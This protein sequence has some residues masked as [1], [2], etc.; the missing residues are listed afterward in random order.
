MAEKDQTLV[1][2]ALAGDGP[3]FGDLVERY[4]RLVRGIIWETVRRPD[5]VE[6]LVQEAFC[7]AYE[8]LPSLRQQAKFASWLWSIAANAALSHQYRKKREEQAAPARAEQQ[9]ALSLY[10]RRP[11]EVAE[12]HEAARL[13]WEALDRLEPESRRLVVL[14]YFEECG[15]QEIARFLDLSVAAVR[16]R[17]FKTRDWLRGE[18]LGKLGAEIQVP[19][20]A[21]GRMREKVMAALPAGFFLAPQP[22]RWLERWAQWKYWA[23]GTAAGLG[24]G[25]LAYQAFQQ[26]ANGLSRE[27]QR[28]E[29]QAQVHGEPSVEWDPPQPRAGQQVRIR[30]ADLEVKAGDQAELH[31]LTDPVYPIDQVV[32]LR[33]EGGIWGTDLVVPEKAV[34][35]SF[36]VTPRREGPQ[37]LRST[38]NLTTR[39]RLQRYQ[40]A[41]LVYDEAGVP[42]RGAAYNQ[43]LLAQIQGRPSE[44]ML[45]W[46]EDELE[47]HPDHF[48]V[49]RL[50]WNALEKTARPALLAQ[51]RA[52][53]ERLKVRY[54]DH[55][56]LLWILAWD[57][58]D[59]QQGLQ[60]LYQRFPEHERAEE[61]AYL[62][63]INAHRDT[64]SR[65]LLVLEEFLTLFPQGRY[66]GEMYRYYLSTLAQ[67]APDRAAQRADSLIGH[68]LVLPL[69]AQQTSMPTVGGRLLEGYA[70][71]LRFDLLLKEGKQAEV[72]PL[73]ERLIASGLADPLPY[74]YIGKK[75]ADQPVPFL[76]GELLSGPRDLP[77]ATQVLEAGLP[78]AAPEQQPQPPWSSD[79]AL[80][81]ESAREEQRQA[82]LDQ[83]L[84][85]CQAYVQ[86]LAQVYLE[87]GDYAQVIR[88][89][90]ESAGLRARIKKYFM[91]DDKTLVL[92][93]KG[94]ER[95][96][97]WEEA[98][99]AYL[100]A[101]AQ[102]YGDPVAEAALQRLHLERYGDLKE[103]ERRL[104]ACYPQAPEFTLTDTRGQEVHLSH[105]RGRPLLLYYDTGDMGPEDTELLARE[106]AKRREILA[107][108]LKRCRQQ[109][110][111]VLG[112]SSLSVHKPFSGR[113]ALDDDGVGD[114]YQIRRTSI[115]LVDRMGRLR[116]RQECRPFEDQTEAEAKVMRKIAE[117]AE[118]QVVDLQLAGVVTSLSEQQ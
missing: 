57:S 73:A 109:G 46:T 41:L 100:R 74:L 24:I 13:V 71:S 112:I 42:V 80:L 114:K 64:P 40:H 90:E 8:Q 94:Y 10:L 70:Y 31:Y 118:E 14:Y 82:Y 21:Q 45:A 50:R 98:E 63:A 7:K 59:W 101:V 43:A 95:L 87:I 9:V 38:S 33:P 96:G 86:A 99:S 18:L 52:E 12:E 77:L 27:A 51:I 2:R 106:G 85:Q 91:E 67:V 36:Y 48:R 5:E 3:A 93:G 68:Q 97:R 22:R 35:L 108:W 15:Y 88:Y 11:D 34:S 49:Y 32:P 44:E 89:L 115:L 65:S 23:I 81:P 19:V 16:W 54:P 53:Q 103:L 75:L 6:D 25:G 84:T 28:L 66:A 62:R 72:R 78:W 116:L 17:L 4:T 39:K 29:Q 113:L 30:V 104:Q 37:E 76:L 92:L 107:K 69:S 26:P 79:D 83:A 105:Y 61:A 55:P 110:V 47:Q 111:A 60:D 117:L 20:R 56:E 58:K 102:N 1:K